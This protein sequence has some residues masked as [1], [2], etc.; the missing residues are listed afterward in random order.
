MKQNYNAKERKRKRESEKGLKKHLYRT[1]KLK[2]EN[3]RKKRE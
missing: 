2:I 3:A 1:P